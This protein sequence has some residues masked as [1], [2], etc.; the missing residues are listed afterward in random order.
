MVEKHRG[1]RCAFVAQLNELKR[2]AGRPSLGRLR[3]L[4]KRALDNGDNERRMLHPSTTQEILSGK[5]VRLPEWP[6]VLSFVIAC[7]DAARQ[8]KLE[9][10]ALGG[11]AEWNARWLAAHE[12]EEERKSGLAQDS[13]VRRSTAA[14]GLEVKAEAGAGVDIGEDSGLV[15]GPGISPLLAT[16]PRSGAAHDD[17]L[18]AV[19]WEHCCLQ[20][21]GRTAARLVPGAE[22]GKEMACFQLALITLLRGCDTDAEHWL[23]RAMKAQISEALALHHHPDRKAEAA[24]MAYPHGC[25]YEAAGGE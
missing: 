7:R 4:S 23:Q 6:W 19:E 16:H 25:D 13:P 8:N 2:Q 9:V 10:W 22:A 21:H 24:K 11:I 5:R 12:V 1:S 3:S 18:S 20:V 14:D 17:R 15:A